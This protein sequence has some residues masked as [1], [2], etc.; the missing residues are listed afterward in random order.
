MSEMM[1]TD[2]QLCVILIKKKKK[3]SPWLMVRCDNFKMFNLYKY[4]YRG[5]CIVSQI[6]ALLVLFHLNRLIFLSCNLGSHMMVIGIPNEVPPIGCLDESVWNV[7]DFTCNIGLQAIFFFYKVHVQPVM[8]EF[9]F[10]LWL[11]R[12]VDI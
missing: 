11:V 9:W 8:N 3:S 12:K 1:M 7:N 5:V 10:A 6:S 2:N 4:E